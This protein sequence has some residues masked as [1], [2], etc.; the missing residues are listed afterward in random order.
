MRRKRGIQTLQHIMLIVENLLLFS[1]KNK[2][3][4]A[5]MNILSIIIPPS[6]KSNITP[7]LTV[8]ISLTTPNLFRSFY[9]ISYRKLKISHFS[10]SPN[11]CSSFYFFLWSI[12]PKSLRITFPKALKNPGIPFI[13]FCGT[14]NPDDAPLLA[15]FEDDVVL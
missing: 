9:L 15:L 14:F 2:R 4:A 7:K 3:C 6:A 13:G 11:I 5:A 10:K 12:I 1:R 8:D